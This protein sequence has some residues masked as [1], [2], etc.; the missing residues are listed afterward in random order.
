M[1]LNA[2]LGIGAA[3]SGSPQVGRP[4]DSSRLRWASARRGRRGMT[5]RPTEEPTLE[6]PHAGDRALVQRALAREAQ[7]TDELVTRLACVPAM[8]RVQQRQVGARLNPDEFADI[9]QSI[10][11]ALWAKLGAYEARAA[12]ET[13]V[14]RFV[15]LELHKALDR[16]RRAHRLALVD[17]ER[18]AELPQAQPEAPQLEPAILRD[19]VDRLGSPTCEI[20]SM[21]HYDELSFEE[22]AR[23]RGE[24]LS[25]VKA[26]YYRG[27]E[28]LKALLEPHLRRQS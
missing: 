16:R 28:R 3:L 21:R 18:L 2:H 10:L 6:D 14:F 12:L 7:A 5:S 23:R 22:I 19:C 4:I 13:W 1:S 17:G 24:A 20:V 15:Q 11:G 25:A 9:E 8:L 27:L 26:R